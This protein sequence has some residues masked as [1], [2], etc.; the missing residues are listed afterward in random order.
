[1][2]NPKCY[3]KIGGIRML[4]KRYRKCFQILRSYDM[5]HN[6]K[7]NIL[8]QQ[9]KWYILLSEYHRHIPENYNQEEMVYGRKQLTD[10]FYK[11][12]S[13]IH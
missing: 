12:N 5:E 7:E 13:I 3:K 10:L 8:M 4:R 6:Y 9:A 1:M 11:I 2:P